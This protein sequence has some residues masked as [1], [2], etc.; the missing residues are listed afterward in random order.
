METERLN[1]RNVGKEDIDFIFQLFSSEK[2]C[3]F[4]YDEEMFVNRN[5]AV[6]F[7]EWNA[8]PEEKGW[9]RWVLVAKDSSRPIGT[10]GYDSWDKTNNIAE[11]GYD[12]WHEYWGRGYM[13][14]ALVSAIE[15]GFSNM[16][17]N[18]INAFIALE[19]VNSIKLLKN[20]GFK[21][22]GIYRDKHLFRGKYYDHYAFS[23]LKR[24]W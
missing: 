13:K 11:I 7:V 20:L 14:E 3:E 16:G 8:E 22:E 18:R 19:N 21:Q 23:L 12:L 15:S 4:L 1:L 9:N 6:D 24:E 5:D 2:V 10:C 17:L